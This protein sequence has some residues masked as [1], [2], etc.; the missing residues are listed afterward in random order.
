MQADLPHTLYLRDKGKKKKGN[1]LENYKFN[2]NDRAIAL[3]M[4]ELEKKR[5]A[6]REKGE[7]VPFETE[8]L[9]KK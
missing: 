9:F 1:P 7:Q 2:P 6:L 5:A 3:Q 8:E 4:E